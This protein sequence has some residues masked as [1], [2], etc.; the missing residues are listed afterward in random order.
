MGNQQFIRYISWIHF[1]V[2]CNILLHYVIFLYFVTIDYYFILKDLI[3]SWKIADKKIGQIPFKEN[4]KMQYEKSLKWI[5]NIITLK[6]RTQL[7]I[8]IILKKC[9]DIYHM[10]IYFEN[11]YVFT[12]RAIR[13]QSFK[14]SD[15]GDCTL[16]IQQDM[17]QL[18][19]YQTN[20]NN[21]THYN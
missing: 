20:Q 13:S 2:F 14:K 18:I 3:N 19:L 8:N 17:F 4:K 16:M 12:G 7:Y 11:V 15:D 1:G 5:F 10:T 6:Q 21:F 9:I